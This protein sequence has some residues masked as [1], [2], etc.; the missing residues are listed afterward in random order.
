MFFAFIRTTWSTHIWN[1]AYCFCLAVCFSIY[2]HILTIFYILLHLFT[3]SF[4]IYMTTII[5]DRCF[6]YA[7]QESCGCSSGLSL[8]K[9]DQVTWSR[10]TGQLPLGKIRAGNYFINTF[11]AT[12]Q[13]LIKDL[14][15]GLLHLLSVFFQQCSSYF[16]CHF[17]SYT[18]T[19]ENQ[20][21]PKIY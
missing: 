7:L 4:L 15:L 9:K 18:T 11:I 19:S 5:I 14:T 1:R 16:F 2:I 6:Q 20:N 17:F 12:R 10:S 13:P 3:F 21:L 8:P